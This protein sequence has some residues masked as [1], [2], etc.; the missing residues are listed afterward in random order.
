[1]KQL[2]EKKSSNIRDYWLLTSDDLSSEWIW[3]LVKIELIFIKIAGN[4]IPK[5]NGYKI[6]PVIKGDQ[7]ISEISAASIIAKVA[8]DRFL[9]KMSKK[10]KK[11]GWDKNVGYGTKQ[12]IKAI[13]KFGITKYHRKTFSP[14]HYML[15]QK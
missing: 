3:S 11:Y 6:K 9:I 2:V 5:I 12:H 1:M 13:Q 4:K 7:K 14:I 10:F 15:S 8:R